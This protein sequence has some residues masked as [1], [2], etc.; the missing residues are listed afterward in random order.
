MR[1]RASPKTPEMQIR[2]RMLSGQPFTYERL[3]AWAEHE[4]SVSDQSERIV[5]RVLWDLVRDN[6]LK[7][8]RR[9][10]VYV[11]TTNAVQRQMLAA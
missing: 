9:H 11:L 2:Q 4:F 8:D 1:A 5:D 10:A 3:V 7:F 6:F